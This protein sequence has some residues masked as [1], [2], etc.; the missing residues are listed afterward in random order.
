ML[1]LEIIDEGCC[2]SCERIP[3]QKASFIVGCNRSR[4]QSCHV[5]GSAKVIEV[6]GHREVADLVLYKPSNFH[7]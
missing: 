1:T 7:F 3:Q 4:A 2:L 6:S 5:G